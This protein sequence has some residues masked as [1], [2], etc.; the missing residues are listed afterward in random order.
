MSELRTRAWGIAL[1]G[2]VS[3]VTG[4][5]V[6]RQ[7][8][9]GRPTITAPIRRLRIGLNDGRV[10]TRMGEATSL[11]RTGILGNADIIYVAFL[12]DG[13]APCSGVA[14]AFLDRLEGVSNDSLIAGIAVL[15]VDSPL[16]WTS[17]RLEAEFLQAWTRARSHLAIVSRSTAKD[18]GIEAF[19]SLVRLDGAGTSQVLLGHEEDFARALTSIR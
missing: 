2:V 12:S 16:V 17:S 13:C 4:A 3:A 15:V 7:I 5:A 14:G 9:E 6:S 8:V 18:W 11:R 1:L 10:Y 19:P